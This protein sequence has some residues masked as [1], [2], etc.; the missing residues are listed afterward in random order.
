M[1]L[2]HLRGNNIWS[3]AIGCHVT[4]FQCA[5]DSLL[6]PYFFYL[7]HRSFLVAQH[8]HTYP[9]P[10]HTHTYSVKRYTFV[11]YIG[12]CIEDKIFPKTN[13]LLA[14]GEGSQKL[15]DI[16]EFSLKI[17]VSRC[18]KLKQLT[19]SSVSL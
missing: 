7:K 2:P 13:S 18:E 17:K 19:G 12:I 10:L 6:I 15:A 9:P 4:D 11:C 1:G 8:L 16:E 14:D 5:I 3:T